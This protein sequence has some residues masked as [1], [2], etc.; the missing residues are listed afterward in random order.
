[1]PI[2]F[3][4]GELRA[5]IAECADND[6]VVIEITK[7]MDCAEQ[8]LYPLSVDIIPGIKMNDQSTIN[9][10]RLVI[11]SQRHFEPPETYYYVVDD[12][13]ADGWSIRVYRLNVAD[14]KLDFVYT[15]H[16]SKAADVLTEL[17][18][19]SNPHDMLYKL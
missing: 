8:D 15:M 2:V 1:M 10:V 14:N 11:E 18:L 7:E 16:I 4:I 5:A 3:T 12:A 13:G 17:R 19:R 9:E 6:A